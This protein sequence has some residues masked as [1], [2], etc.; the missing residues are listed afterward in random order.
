[1]ASAPVDATAGEPVELQLSLVGPRRSVLVRVAGDPE[2]SRFRMVPPVQG[3]T[4]RVLAPGRG[5]YPA[6][7]LV[8]DVAGLLSGAHL[9]S[10]VPLRAP[11]D[12][13]PRPEPTDPVEPLLTSLRLAEG[14]RPVAGWPGGDHVR[15]VREYVPGDSR[16]TVHWPLTARHGRLV[17]REFEPLDDAE[18]VLLVVDLGTDA[19]DLAEG[20]AS[21]AAHLGRS[22]LARGF[23][24]SCVTL[25]PGGAVDADVADAVTLGRRLARAVPSGAATAGGSLPTGPLD[26]PAVV[27][28][29]EG[30]R[31]RGPVRPHVPP[32]LGADR[33]DGPRAIG[34]DRREDLDVVEVGRDEPGPQR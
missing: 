23:R 22:F 16:R 6:L 31:V 18:R 26:R 5:S 3:A 10:E 32:A 1:V 4:L 9:S 30:A 24:L 34:T 17:V 20:V 25:E 19:G 7:G 28:S 8:V 12:V 13:G 15:S 33:P 14:D 21:R 27:V 29:P 2:D 11:I